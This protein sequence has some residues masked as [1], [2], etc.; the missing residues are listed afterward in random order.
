METTAGT[1]AAL[2]Q[3]DAN[4]TVTALDIGDGRDS[5]FLLEIGAGAIGIK[6]TADQ[7][8]ALVASA[9]EAQLFDAE[10]VDAK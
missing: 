6:L 5:R 8:R 9:L 2:I 10:A 7:L 1:V 3:T 4:P